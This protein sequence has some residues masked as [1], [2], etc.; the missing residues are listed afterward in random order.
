MMQLDESCE[1]AE[2]GIIP[3][4]HPTKPNMALGYK[5]RTTWEQIK[6]Q[7]SPSFFILSCPGFEGISDAARRLIVS[8]ADLKKVCCWTM[9][10]K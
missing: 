4:F 6:L 5:L 2:L 8:A 7:V 3:R 10:A 1:H 9:Q